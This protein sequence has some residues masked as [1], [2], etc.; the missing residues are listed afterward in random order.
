M[1]ETVPILL[2]SSGFADMPHCFY[3]VAPKLSNKLKEAYFL[4]ILLNLNLWTFPIE[5]VQKSDLN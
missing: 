2:V 1:Q 4:S 5:N 3:V